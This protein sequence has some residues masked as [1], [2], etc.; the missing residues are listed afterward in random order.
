[1]RYPIVTKEILK[2]DQFDI[3]SLE[4]KINICQL[5]QF[6]YSKFNAVNE[7]QEEEIK[8]PSKPKRTRRPKMVEPKRMEIYFIAGTLAFKFQS[9]NLAG[10]GITD[11]VQAESL[12]LTKSIKNGTILTPSVNWI[13]DVTR[14]YNLF[15]KHHPLPNLR[16][17]P[18]LVSE[19]TK[20]LQTNFP[21]YDHA[22]LKEFAFIRT[23][24][25][26]KKINEIARQGKKS[27]VRGARNLVETI[28]N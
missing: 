26:I 7:E 20:V 6:D 24:L 12:F 17:G 3:F 16:Q 1:M 10:D 23:N 27:T 15:K 18:G 21:N 14:M 22:V 8:P 4:E 9:A 2:D 19:F 5:Y 25:Q 28:N 13:K 11:D